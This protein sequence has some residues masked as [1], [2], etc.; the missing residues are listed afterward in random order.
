[1]LFKE[2]AAPRVIE[3]GGDRDI[4]EN[5]SYPAEAET[6]TVITRQ[7]R[8]QQANPRAR[9]AHVCLASALKRGIVEKQPCK[10]CGSEK[11]DAHHDDYSRPAEVTW[12]C[13]RHHVQLHRDRRKAGAG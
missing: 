11:V 4:T 10:V 2:N 5:K 8:W 1:L 9:W 13:R 6:A 3:S 12:L 7:L